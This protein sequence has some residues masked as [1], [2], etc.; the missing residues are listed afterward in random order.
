[1]KK[2]R[3]HIKS[4]NY[5]INFKGR[6]VRTPCYID[7]NNKKEIQYWIDHLK[8]RLLE[9]EIENDPEQKPK[10]KVVIPS[11]PKSKNT[12]KSNTTILDKLTLNESID[13]E[14]QSK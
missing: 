4:S 2:K 5:F 13:I 12:K 3:I 1:M 14:E 8:A 9:Y 10:P 7:L 6:S 11:K